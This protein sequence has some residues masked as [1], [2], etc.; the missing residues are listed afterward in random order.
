MKYLPLVGL[1]TLCGVLPVQAQ[2]RAQQ[3]NSRSELLSNE[4]EVFVA[5]DQYY[6]KLKRICTV[7]DPLNNQV[8]FRDEMVTIHF[9][10]H[11][12]FACERTFL[13]TEADFVLR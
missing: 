5:I 12:E 3:L 13:K 9:T 2:S 8:S 6:E 10:N 7:E 1:L 11:T 4:G